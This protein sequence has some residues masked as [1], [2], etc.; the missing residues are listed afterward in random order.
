M[1]SGQVAAGYAPSVSRMCSG[2]F[3]SQVAGG[4]CGYG[5]VEGVPEVG[6]SPL[7][8]LG[9]WGFLSIFQLA[10]PRTWGILL[11]PGKSIIL[12]G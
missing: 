3:L 11:D 2:G 7:G 4:V 9:K 10:F 8:V 12:G 5:G 6:G 1:A